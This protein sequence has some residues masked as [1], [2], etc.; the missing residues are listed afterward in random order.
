MVAPRPYY[1]PETTK[2]RQYAGVTT[3]SR[4]VFGGV[5]QPC[6]A[7]LFETAVLVFASTAVMTEAMGLNAVATGSALV[8]G[9][10]YT[11]LIA[12]L[13]PLR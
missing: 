4:R 3:A 11:T 5:V 6:L 2:R 9:L 10:T 12:T 1:T 7:E 13:G 8:H